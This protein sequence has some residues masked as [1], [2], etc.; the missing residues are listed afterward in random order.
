VSSWCESVVA[1]THKKRAR[2]PSAWAT[3]SPD[4]GLALKLSGLPP[5]RA[6]R[7]AQS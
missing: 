5:D 1:A 2:P 4:E 7:N 6:R 3:R